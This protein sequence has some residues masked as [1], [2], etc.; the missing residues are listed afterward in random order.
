MF[1]NTSRQHDAV[2]NH[3]FP[4]V[5]DPSEGLEITEVRSG[6]YQRLDKDGNPLRNFLLSPYAEVG[7]TDVINADGTE[8]QHDK[9][10][11]WSRMIQAKKLR[12][13]RLLPLSS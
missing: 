11:E 4:D 8:K 1:L 3:V 12:N 2:F 10:K 6:P 5:Q 13:Q 9:R 7:E